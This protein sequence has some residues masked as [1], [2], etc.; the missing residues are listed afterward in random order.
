MCMCVCMCMCM[1]IPAMQAK[2]CVCVLPQQSLTAACSP[3]AVA[4]EEYGKKQRLP[5]EVNNIG[6]VRVDKDG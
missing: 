3:G 5:I 4:I 2:V 1:C 6:Q